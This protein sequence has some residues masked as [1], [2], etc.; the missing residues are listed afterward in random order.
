M[1]KLLLQRCDLRRLHVIE[2][3]KARDHIVFCAFH[4]FLV[5]SKRMPTIAAYIRAAH[6]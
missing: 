5:K 1:E 4:S 2:G 3:Q 6:W